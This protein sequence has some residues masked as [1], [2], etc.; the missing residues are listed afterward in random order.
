M[1]FTI[2]LRLFRIAALITLHPVVSI[3][4]SHNVNG[5]LKQS[6]LS[7]TVCLIIG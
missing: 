2:N 3:L 4:K 6:K 7:G 5:P 1:Q